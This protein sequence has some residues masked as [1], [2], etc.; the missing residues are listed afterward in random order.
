[1]TG[2]Q[3]CALPIFKI[4]FAFIE[5]ALMVK[6]LSNAD[7]VMHWGLLKREVF[8]GIWVLIGAATTAYLFGWL[9]FGDASPAQALSKP[10]IMAGVLFAVFTISLI[11]GLTNTR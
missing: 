6:F 3:T 4:V 8:I 9:R 11:P 1:M 5:L 10:R 2:V 7:L